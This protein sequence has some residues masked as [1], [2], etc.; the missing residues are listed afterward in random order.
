MNF[1]R[2]HI[3]LTNNCNFSCAFCPDVALA[4][5]RGSMNFNL[6]CKA[7]DEI[8]QEKLTKQILFHI[9]GDPLLYPYLEKAVRYAG[10]RELKVYLTTNGWGMTEEL[11]KKLLDANVDYVLFSVQTPD[12]KSFKLRRVN[13]DFSQYKKHIATSIAEI[14]ERR[15]N[16]TA[17]LSLLTTPF[18]KIIFPSRRFHIIDTKVDLIEH[19]NCWIEEILKEITTKDVIKKIHAGMGKVQKKL[20]K[21]NMLGWNRLKVLDNFILETRIL[22]DWVHPGLYAEKVR[23][24]TIGC[25]EGLTKH[26][27]ILWDGGMVF[28]CV[29]FDGYTRFANLGESTIKEAFQQEEVKNINGFK[30][31]HIRHPYCQ[32]CLGD[33]SLKSALVRQVGSI[34]YFKWYRKRWMAKRREE[35]AL[36]S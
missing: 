16:T 21:F 10:D 35:K 13:V 15:E 14:I 2:I 25:C 18:N 31:F 29:D 11:L 19:F 36:I 22:G 30:K 20:S 33:V 32:R 24:A 7:L 4:R 26:F 3:E 9:M 8:S 23:K 12:E 17:I 5:K 28:C 1:E 6:L 27:G 34:I